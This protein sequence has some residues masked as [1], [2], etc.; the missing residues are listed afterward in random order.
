M[1]IF[2]V[3]CRLKAVSGSHTIALAAKHYSVPVSCLSLLLCTRIVML[4]E[5]IHTVLYF[6]LK[7]C[8]VLFFSISC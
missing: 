6:V 7:N 3:C 1:S 4:S 2:V 8:K 5:D